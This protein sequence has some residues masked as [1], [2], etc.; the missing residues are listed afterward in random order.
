ML[1]DWQKKHINAKLDE[2]LSK[3]DKDTKKVYHKLFAASNEHITQF[4]G[5]FLGAI[6]LKIETDTNNAETRRQFLGSCLK[7]KIPFK[8]YAFKLLDPYPY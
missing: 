5:E 6:L 2:T 4:S 7:Q 1:K 3:S 8:N